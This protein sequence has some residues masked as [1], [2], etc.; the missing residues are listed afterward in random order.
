MNYRQRQL[1]QATNIPPNLTLV[2][3]GMM[4]LAALALMLYFKD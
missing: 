4:A 2:S 3:G 1:G